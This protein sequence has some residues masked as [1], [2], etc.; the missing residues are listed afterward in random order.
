[1]SI[2]SNLLIEEKIFNKVIFPNPYMILKNKNIKNVSEFSEF[3]KYYSYPFVNYKSHSNNNI[4]FIFDNSLTGIRYSSIKLFDSTNTKTLTR[5]IQ[6]RPVLNN[7]IS[8]IYMDL[9]L[10]IYIYL[11]L[12]IIFKILK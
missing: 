6:Y 7:N 3:S 12:I 5:N 4:S 1:M 2:S 11:E 10:Q 9:P 8:N